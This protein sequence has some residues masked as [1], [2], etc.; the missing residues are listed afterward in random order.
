MAAQLD[1]NMGMDPSMDGTLQQEE[2]EDQY[3]NS[4]EDAI[5]QEQGDADGEAPHDSDHLQHLQANSQQEAEGHIA[6]VL[7]D[8]AAPDEAGPAE[9]DSAS[10]IGGDAAEQQLPPLRPQVC[11]LLLMNLHIRTNACTYA[12]DAHTYLHLLLAS[13]IACCWLTT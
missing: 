10:P 3:D 12:S 9:A 6:Q 13:S 4:L 7:R 5:H 8:R 11:L 2:E 1:P